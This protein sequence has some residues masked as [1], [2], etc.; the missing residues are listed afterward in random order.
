[1]LLQVGRSALFGLQFHVKGKSV[2]YQMQIRQS[3]LAEAAAPALFIV[4]DRGNGHPVPR[5]AKGINPQSFQP[6]LHAVFKALF[7]CHLITSL[8]LFDKSARFD[9]REGCF[10]TL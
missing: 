3:G 7:F 10:L 8:F 9:M 2:H 1:M 6:T 4:A 5:P